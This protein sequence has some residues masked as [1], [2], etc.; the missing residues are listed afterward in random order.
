VRYL[1]AGDID[2][3]A[4]AIALRQR[5]ALRADVLK[6]PRHGSTTASS[7]EFISAVRPRLAIISAGARGRSESQRDQVSE[8]YRAIGAEV[9]RT[10][11]DGAITIRTDGSEFSYEGYKSGRRGVIKY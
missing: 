4:E 5:D 2:K 6:V 8:R 3:R 11:H 1:F 10:D 7:A 9:F